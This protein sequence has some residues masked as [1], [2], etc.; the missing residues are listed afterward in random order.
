MSEMTDN[1][2][3]ERNSYIDLCRAIAVLDVLAGH[4]AF[5]VMFWETPN[6]LKSLTLLFEVPTFFFLSG[7]RYLNLVTSFAINHPTFPASQP[8]PQTA[9]YR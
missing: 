3:K 8:R 9:A 4:T 6:W 1:L 2:S 7:F 5:W